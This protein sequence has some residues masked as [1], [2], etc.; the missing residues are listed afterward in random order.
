MF[1]QLIDKEYIITNGL[2]GFSSSSLTGANTRKYHSILNASLNPPVNRTVLLSRLLTTININDKDHVLESTMH[3]GQTIDNTKYYQSFSDLPLPT[4][5]YNVEGCEIKKEIAMVYGQNTSAVVY[6]IKTKEPLKLSVELHLNAR[7]HH[8]L[9]S[10]GDFNYTLEGSDTHLLF[11][12]DLADLYIDGFGHYETINQWAEKE[13]Y[14]I[15]ERR[16]QEDIDQNYIPGKFVISIPEN[17]TKR[18]AVI[19][20]TQ[21]IEKDFESIITD[22]LNRREGLYNGQDTTMKRLIIGCDHFIVDRQSTKSKTVIAGY[23]W[24]TDWGRDTM[25]ALPGLTLSTERYEDAK[26][27]IRTFIKYEKEGLIPNM[28]PDDNVEP[29]Y[30]TIDGTLWLFIAVYEYVQKTGDIDF[31][32][33]IYPTLNRIVGKHIEGTT[34]QIHVDT[35]GL[36]SGGDPTTQ[37]TWMDVKID[38]VVVTP[39]HGKA[40]EINAL[41]FNALNIMDKLTRQAQIDQSIDYK[42][43]S[44]SCKE[45]FNKRFWNE[46]NNSLFDLIQDDQ[47]VDRIRP[48]Q[49]FA[50]SLPFSILNQDKEKAVIEMVEKELLTPFGLRS[51]SRDH[52]DY[53][54]VYDGDVYKRDYA[55]HQ[56]TVWGWLIGPYLEA[57][58]KTYKDKAYV[59][60]KLQGLFDHLN[61]TG[62]GTISEVF[63]GDHP[64]HARGCFGQAWSVSETL[65]IY[66][67]IQD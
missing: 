39:R 44:L 49:I 53:K 35:D 14:K 2:G 52:A 43:Y 38:G 30:N 32:K 20:S 62:M 67:M 40:V 55:Y 46:A 4:F 42:K 15:E 13:Y 19:A 21:S 23:P 18:I 33:E 7:D 37:L 31:F 41:W 5:T 10:E 6:T 50:V 58:Y 65:R 16:G 57:H 1:N 9:S 48:N 3:E 45:S 27:I 61:D 47:P 63:S 51:L 36:L 28:F 66:K 26:D 34:Y 17:T 8:D 25:I 29:M 11:K 22:E 56:G 60:D 24:F 12:N 54:P 59:L 64:H